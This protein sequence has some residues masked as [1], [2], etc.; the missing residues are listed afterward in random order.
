MRTTTTLVA[1]AAFG[2]LLAAC[3]NQKEPAEKAVAKVEAALAEFRADAEQYAAGQLQQVDRSIANLKNNLAR[4]DYAAVVRGAPAVSSAV[5]TLRAHVTRMKADAAEML[6]TAQQEWNAMAASVPQLV[7]DLEARV[8]SFARSRKLP[9][10]FTQQ[11]FS[12]AQATFED[13]KKVW[14]EA[15]AEAA[16][17]K[18]ADAVRK[19]R[20]VKMNAEHLLRRLAA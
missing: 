13:I 16:E 18:V 14:A 2:L 3:A 9:R 20:V 17:G 15:S 7:S 1:G 11:D 19:A 8:S 5:S 10:D 4:E 6:A 12:L